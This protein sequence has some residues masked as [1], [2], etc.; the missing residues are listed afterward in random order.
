MYTCFEIVCLC[1]I[2]REGGAWVFGS[3]RNNWVRFGGG[4]LR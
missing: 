1:V 2:E 4:G 3:A